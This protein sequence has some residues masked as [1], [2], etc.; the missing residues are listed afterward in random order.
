MRLTWMLNEV[1]TKESLALCR[2]LAAH[3]FGTLA[4][5]D[6]LYQ[7]AC[8]HVREGA[9]EEGAAV[10]AR[11]IELDPTQADDARKDSD[12]IPHAAHPAFAKLLAH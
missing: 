3:A 6:F 10:L 7:W 11:A 9:L 2:A 5:P 12:I 4:S 1:A 8:A